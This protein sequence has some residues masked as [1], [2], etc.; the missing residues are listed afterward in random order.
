MRGEDRKCPTIGAD[1]QRFTNQGGPFGC[2]LEHGIPEARAKTFRS[3][4]RTN[5]AL[6]H[7]WKL[8]PAAIIFKN[9]V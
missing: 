7:Y 1:G 2:Y 6:R 4:L 9:Y 5:E 3:K 8:E